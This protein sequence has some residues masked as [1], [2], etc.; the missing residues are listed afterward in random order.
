MHNAPIATGRLH[1]LRLGLSQQ[2][3]SELLL[4]HGSSHGLQRF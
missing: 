1:V 4:I 3:F 2:L